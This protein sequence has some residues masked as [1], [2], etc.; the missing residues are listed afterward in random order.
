MS[1]SAADKCPTCG[2]YPQR[3]I[4]DLIVQGELGPRQAPIVHRA[5]THLQAVML[6]LDGERRAI[7]VAEVVAATAGCSPVS[8]RS[9]LLAAARAGLVTTTYRKDLDG[10]RRA[11]VAWNRKER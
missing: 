1:R 5:W 3:Q 10:H 11:Y 7:D 6:T 4:A 8:I 2:R 9:L